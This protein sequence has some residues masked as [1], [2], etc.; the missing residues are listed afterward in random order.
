MTAQFPAVF[1]C[2]L[3]ALTGL[4]AASG[5]PDV[6]VLRLPD[7]GLQPRAQVDG[8]GSVHVVYFKGP[9]DAGDVWY[10][11]KRPGEPGFG[12]PVRVN[13]QAGSAVAVGT[14]RGPHLA[15]G[16]HGRVHVAWNGASKATPRGPTDASGVAGDPMLYARMN[17][18]A[19]G[20]EPQRCV[21]AAS[22]TLDGGGSI[23]ADTEGRVFVGWHAAPPSGGSDE[24]S[25]R[26]WV[27]RSTDDGETFQE[28]QPVTP[29]GLGACACCGT[30][31]AVDSANRVHFIF[32]SARGNE[33]RDVH[34][35]S[36]RDHGN[37]F[38]AR[39][40]HAWK[41]NQCPMTNAWITEVPKGG[42][43][44][45]VLA[46]ETKGQVYF[47]RVDPDS[48]TMSA[49]VCP[50]GGGNNRKHPAVAA[51]ATG[52]VLMAWTEGTGWAEGGS[53]A[54]E[55]FGAD[56]RPVAGSRAVREG[57][58]GLVVWNS[59]AVVAADGRFFVVY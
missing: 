23:A 47:A 16:R 53:V 8:E 12:T 18:A 6:A 46:W 33:E 32:R 34:W 35:L 55:L 40:L 58:E 37:T 31:A 27:A 59:V 44:P 17:V 9:A 20:F 48:G 49:P 54:W 52:L 15:L 38:S 57:G 28:E 50:A 30:A 43:N 56:D 39:R 45:L 19:T 41:L 25:R 14:I 10:V 13:S 3:A 51:D 7:A 29:V 24:A 22:T 4:A 42:S 1:T 21:A 5:V 11:C 2:I 26:F 36:S